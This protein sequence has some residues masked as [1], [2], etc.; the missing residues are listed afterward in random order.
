MLQVPRSRPAVHTFDAPVTAL[1]FD[2]GASTVAFALGDGTVR[3]GSR[4]DGF[5]SLATVSLHHGAVLR[6]VAET[7]PGAFLSGGDD[8]RALRIEADGSVIE[9]A[10]FPGCWIEELAVSPVTEFRAIAAD[11]EV[12]LYDRQGVLLGAAAEHPSTVAGIAFNPKGKRLAIAHYGG[13]TLRWC[14][15]ID[16]VPVDLAF[17]GSHIGVSWSPD[18]AWLMTSM[19][20]RELH[21]WPLGGKSAEVRMGGY[22]AKVRSMDWSCRSGLLATSG[23]QGAILWSFSGRGP[24][25][26]QPVVLAAREKALVTRVAWH[27]RLPV[28]AAGFDDGAVVAAALDASAELLLRPPGGGAVE[29]LAWSADG[30]FLAAGTADGEACVIDLDPA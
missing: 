3:L 30:T 12:R 22:T 24:S 1:A 25:G 18:G 19:Q 14:S 2:R 26:R 4:A 20:E 15:G 5:T 8:G 6:L 13:V 27:P 9:L 11:R 16:G 23:S 7:G 10:S 21:G 28:L 29:A 17:P